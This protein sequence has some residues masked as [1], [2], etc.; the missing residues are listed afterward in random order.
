MLNVNDLPIDIQIIIW[1]HVFQ[2]SL[3]VIN[4]YHNDP[5]RECNALIRYLYW[6][7]YKDP[8]STQPI[9]GTITFGHGLFV[10]HLKPL[11]HTEFKDTNLLLEFTEYRYHY[12]FPTYVP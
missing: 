2:D 1:K 5:W 3:E 6:S 9:S 12:Y 8:L 10:T 7:A 11:F 4:S